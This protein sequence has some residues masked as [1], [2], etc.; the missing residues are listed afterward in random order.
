MA[1]KDNKNKMIIAISVS[2]VVC[3]GLIIGSFFLG[4]N[5][6]SNQKPEEAG[7]V[8]GAD[9]YPQWTLSGAYRRSFYNNYNKSVESYVVLKENGSCK[10]ISM[11]AS[12]YATTADLTT[13]D[14]NCSYT[15][16]ESS[17]IGEIT[18]KS[19][20][21]LIDENGDKKY[22]EPTKLKF[23]YDS[24]SFMLGGATYYR[25]Q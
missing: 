23:N 22:G 24:G 11:L 9:S 21:Y 5:I 17:K 6:G 3:L 14:E 7:Y 16:D 13:M 15:Y 18:I 25:V 4:Y 2:S 12:E 20:S 1:K 10:Y 8:N 19:S